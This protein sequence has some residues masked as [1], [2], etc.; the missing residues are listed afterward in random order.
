MAKGKSQQK[1]T[2]TPPKMTKAEKKK[3]KNA[4]PAYFSA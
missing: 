3:A 4:P 2:K 1:A